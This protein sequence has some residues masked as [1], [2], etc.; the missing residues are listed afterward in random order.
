MEKRG[1]VM[2][3][4]KELSEKAQERLQTD[5]ERERLLLELQH[6]K[7]QLQQ[8]ARPSQEH[9]TNITP[10]TENE[11]LCQVRRYINICGVLRQSVMHKLCFG[12]CAVPPADLCEVRD[13]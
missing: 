8:I 6:V 13:E 9:T 5:G 4:Q 11:G 7:Q 10:T 3:L 2:Q 12:K 1:H